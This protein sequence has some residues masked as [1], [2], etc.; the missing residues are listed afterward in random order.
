[1]AETHGRGAWTAFGK[2]NGS[3]Y[4]EYIARQPFDGSTPEKG[5]NYEAVHLGV[6]AIQN[7]LVD[8]GYDGRLRGD[9]FEVDGIYGRRTRRMV[10]FYQKDND[11][12]VSGIVGSTTGK[13]MFRGS[14]MEWGA[15]FKFNPAYVYGIM[16]QESGGDP[17]AVGYLTPGD[18]GLY[19]FNT[20]VHDIS[21]KQAHDYTYANDAMFARFD[22]AWH[23]YRGK[24]DEL[25]VNCSIAQHNAPTWANEWFMYGEPPNSTIE[26]YVSKVKAFAETF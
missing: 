1:M 4:Y 16:L 8:L 24:G 19:Q 7:R 21:Y 25:R 15:S 12:T 5:P 3:I 17:G 13:H 18:R 14:I 26:S 22:N 23:K 6:L 11:I 20:L 2:D 10:K 9:D